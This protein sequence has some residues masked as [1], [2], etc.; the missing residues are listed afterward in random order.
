[1]ASCTIFM[2]FEVLNIVILII[3]K[4]ARDYKLTSDIAFFYVRFTIK[5]PIS[6]ITCCWGVRTTHLVQ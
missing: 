1:M 2:Y 3:L 6:H 5:V 4:K